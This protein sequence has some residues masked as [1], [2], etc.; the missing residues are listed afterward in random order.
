MR[1]SELAGRRVG[2]LGLGLE[3]RAALAH[4]H[5][6]LPGQS[7][8]IICEAEPVDPG[9]LDPDRDRLTVSPLAEAGL[10]RFDVLV[11][12]PGISPYRPS[13]A[14]FRS[15]GGLLTTASSL[16][17]AEHP[18]A[19]TLCITGTK[20]K[21]TT[22]ALT[23]HLLRAAGLSVVVGGNYGAPMLAHSGP[24]PDWWVIE[25]SSY[26]LADLEARPSLGGI[27]NLSDEH[28]DWHGG[29]ESYR[30]DKLRLAQLVGTRP[31]VANGADKGL[32]AAL[33]DRDGTRWFNRHGS[34]Q[35]GDQGVSHFGHGL[36]GLR[37]ARLPGRHNL[38]NLAAALALVEQTGVLDA[39][40]RA[41][42]PN[43][44]A[45]FQGLPHRLHT[46]GQRD[47]VRF[48]DDSLSTTPV[49][50]LAALDAFRDDRVV[51]LVGGADRGLDWS[52]LADRFQA[53][54]PWAMVALP[55]NGP[56]VMEQ[57]RAGGFAPPAG[58]H[59]AEDLDE[60]VEL[61]RSMLPSGGTVLLSPGAPSFG[62]F[63]DYRARG[64]AFAR[65]SALDKSN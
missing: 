19:R 27:T 48:V 24:E 47:G 45:D 57:L 28:L 30:R 37:L 11:R 8:D 25:L 16:W 21:S 13:L 35:A 1:A 26:Q 39:P 10:E 63:T 53:A 44:L 32:V 65:A 3:G 29:A 18:T 56:H 58:L 15:G 42:L 22:T 7:F 59:I 60:A 40:L 20:G 46:L 33:G 31:L 54:A 38:D 23:A 52:G 5:A 50:T 64:H 34:W 12:S 43:V 62:R 9:E 36:E 41:R 51:V 17:F 61:A 55:D 6:C 49:A 2:V 4:L 14:A